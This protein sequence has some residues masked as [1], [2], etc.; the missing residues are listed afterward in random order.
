MAN[1]DIPIVMAYNRVMINEIARD[2]TRC[3]KCPLCRTRN[4]AVPGE[5]R[6]DAKIMIVGEAPGAVNDE[7]GR[8]FVGHG[9]QILDKI[10]DRC[11]VRRAD[12]F[13]T[14]VIKCRPPENRKPTKK[15]IAACRQYLSRQI[16][17]INPKLI[18]ALGSVAFETITG[19]T[20]RTKENCGR[21]FDMGG[22]KVGLCIHPNA[23]RYV[24]GGLD[25]L[26]EQFSKV[27]C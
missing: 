24:K 8:P 20:V 25:S 2:I 11:G 12:L 22:R 14:N 5:G 27:I 21:V 15:E 4:K 19:Q 1:L 3:D 6:A 9:G 16:D 10:L 13:I 17:S 7:T 23:L 18:I 26:A